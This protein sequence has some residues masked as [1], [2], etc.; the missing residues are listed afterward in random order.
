MAIN[1]AWCTGV[2]ALMEWFDDHAEQ[3]YYSVWRG[4]NLSFSWNNDDMEAGR[5]KLLNDIT[6][7][8]IAYLL[9]CFKLKRCFE[10]HRNVFNCVIRFSY[11]FIHNLY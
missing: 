9:T 2:N 10:I 7:S 8:L 1:K 11:E 6:F 4:R 3:P 5:L